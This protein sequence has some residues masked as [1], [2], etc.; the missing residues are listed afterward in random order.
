MPHEIEGEE[1]NAAFQ[2]IGDIED[3]YTT[4]AL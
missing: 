1:A 4:T 2:C 3:G